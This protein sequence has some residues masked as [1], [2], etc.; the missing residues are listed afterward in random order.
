MPS[1]YSSTLPRQ[2]PLTPPDHFDAYLGNAHGSGQLPALQSLGAS[3]Y[4]LGGLERR[5]SLQQYSQYALAPR[6]AYL[7]DNNRPA[8][9]NYAS[10]AGGSLNAYVPASGL[11]LPPLR[12]P[13]RSLDDYQQQVRSKRAPTVPKPKEEK[14]VGGVAAILDYE[15]E[16]MVDFVSETSQGM[17][18][19]FASK[20]CLADIDMTRSVLNSKSSVH[21]DFRKYVSQVLSSTRLPSSTILLGLHYLAKR[22][23]ML[24]TGGK[25]SSGS[26]Q[27]YHMLTTA[28]LLGSKFLDDNTFQNRSWSEVSNIPVSELNVLEVEWLV[29]IQWDMHIDPNDPEGFL[30]WLNRWEGYMDKKRQFTRAQVKSELSLVTES[31]NR[32]SLDA[33]TPINGGMVPRQ[34]SL[35]QRSTPTNLPV[36]SFAGQNIG[37]V[38]KDHPQPKWNTARYDPWPP[39][40]SHRDY[41][42]PS[43]PETGPNTPEWYGN[44]GAFGYGQVPQQT[45]LPIK[46]P[47][48]LQI[49]GSNASQSGY[50]T[51]YAQQYN[52]YGHGSNCGC[53]YCVAHYDRFFMAPGYGPQPVVG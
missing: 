43:A 13:D 24:S 18:D 52:P 11:L 28:L 5:D 8:P 4:E 41:S 32:T 38:Y 48:P 50:N 49:L 25:Y 21:P 47:A 31:L 33:H 37:S 42:P 35:H 36:P 15:M 20:I 19:I 30:L 27:V 53:S 16:D 34:Q 22:M 29:A 12:V 7:P 40:H 17:Y 1:F 26:G 3:N 2:M 6:P 51:P 45:Y 9:P 23:T 10:Q 46:M 39:L 44:Y 14:P